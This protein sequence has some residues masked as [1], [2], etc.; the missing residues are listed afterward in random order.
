MREMSHE[1]EEK[2]E[3]VEGGYLRVV[4]KMVVWRKKGIL[5][6]FEVEEGEVELMKRGAV[7]IIEKELNKMF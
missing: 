4:R 7:Q 5:Q 3:D 6:K 1:E 2:D